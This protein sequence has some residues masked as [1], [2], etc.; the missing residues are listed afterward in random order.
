MKGLGVGISLVVQWLRLLI[1]NAG[2]L[3]AILG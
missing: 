1:P 3:G 2:G